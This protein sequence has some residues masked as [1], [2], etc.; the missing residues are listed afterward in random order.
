MTVDPQ[1]PLPGSW[2]TAL[3]SYDG[4]EGV[5]DRVEVAFGRESAALEVAPVDRFIAT[6]WWSAHI[7]ARAARDLGGARRLPLPDPGVRAVHVP[8]GHATRRSPSESYRFPHV[9]L[10][11]TELLRDFFRGRGIGVYADGRASATARPRRSRTRSPPSTPPTADELAARSSRRLL[12][13]ARPEAH[14][15][16][17]MF[18]LGVLALRRALARGRVRRLGA[19]RDRHG[20]RR[21]AGSPLGDGPRSSC[22]RGRRRAS[23]RRLLREHDVGLALMY[24]PHPSLVPIEMAS[25]GLLDRHQQL[26]EQDRRADERRS[27]PT[28]STAD[29]ERRRRSPPRCWRRGGRGGRRRAP[30]ARRARGLEPRLGRARSP[31]RCSTR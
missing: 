11:S 18:E 14:A 31:T 1:P 16:R 20:R 29:A 27:R 24:T 8:D 13:Y 5:F 7:A 17:N 26:R 25:A 6:T 22:C 2:P 12:F 4:L 3:E 23:T 15:A 10:F 28:S 30:R 21:A 9:A 19:A